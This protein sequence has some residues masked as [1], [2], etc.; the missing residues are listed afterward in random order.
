MPTSVTL[1]NI[2]DS[3]SVSPNNSSIYDFT[4][5]AD[6]NCSN[7]INDQ[8]NIS[9][10]PVPNTIISG[11]GS[12]CDDGSQVDVF[13][14]TSSGTPPFNAQYSVGIETKFLSNI[15]YN[16]TIST[17][18]A[19]LYSLIKISDSKGCKANTNGFA[20]VYINSIP[21]VDFTFYPQPVDLN[22]PLVFF[23]DQSTSHSSGYWN[24]GDNSPYIN[25]N[26]GEISHLYSS[27]DSATYNVTL[28][29][30][31]DSGCTNSITKQIVINKSFSIYI[32]WLLQTMT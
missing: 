7:N 30:S 6:P 11:G 15:G 9:I 16:H 17:N 10:N 5:V 23:V 21:Q 1:S 26:F 18:D 28:T 31:S 8:I 13:I 22:N 4:S 20:N 19:G 25:T 3:I 27:Q 12:V 24:F 29:I 32:L 2:N 14:N